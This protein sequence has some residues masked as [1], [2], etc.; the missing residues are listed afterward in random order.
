M[1][2]RTLYAR[3]REVRGEE[4]ALVDC[5]VGDEKENAP[6]RGRVPVVKDVWTERMQWDAEDVEAIMIDII[7]RKIGRYK[8]AR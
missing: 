6:E 1:G 3:G 7:M 8:L 5:G 4:L 2:A